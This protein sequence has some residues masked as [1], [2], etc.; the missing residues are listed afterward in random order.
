MGAPGWLTA[1]PIAHRGFHDADARYLENTVAAAEA[2]ISRGFAVECD[3]RVTADGEAMVFHDES[4]DRLTGR[5]GRVDQTTGADIAATPLTGTGDRIPTLAAFLNAIAGRVPVFIELKSNFDGDQRLAR[6]TAEVLAN[7]DGPAAVMSFDP[8][9]VRAM[10]S[11]APDRPRG[12][13]CGRFEA[14][15]FPRLSFLRRL[16]LR[17]L[18]TAPWFGLSFIACNIDYLPATVPLAFKRL[19]IPLV[20]W[21]VRTPVHRRK[22]Q[23]FADQVIFERFDPTFTDTAS[24]GSD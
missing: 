1:S 10:R 2:A 9:Q 22:A 12:L 15:R 16:S 11:L 18:L 20:T 19:G 21:T 4:L 6:R 14:S 5:A 13:V 23:Q 3:L 7:Y 8:S 24:T 17:Y